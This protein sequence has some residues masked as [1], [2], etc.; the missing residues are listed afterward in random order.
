MLGSNVELSDQI[1][2]A[3]EN[4]GMLS[5]GLNS[6]K[7]TSPHVTYQN[8]SCKILL[9]FFLASVKCLE[10]GTFQ[11]KDIP[12]HLQCLSCLLWNTKFP[13]VPAAALLSLWV[14][15]SCQELNWEAMK[16]SCKC[17]MVQKAW[18]TKENKDRLWCLLS[19]A[20]SFKLAKPGR[21]LP[22]SSCEQL[23]SYFRKIQG[24]QVKSNQRK[25]PFTEALASSM[26]LLS[27]KDIHTNWYDLG[28][29]SVPLMLSLGL[30]AEFYGKSMWQRIC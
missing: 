12:T 15:F 4:A 27:S 13:E 1:R 5:A 11:R 21:S 2:E 22:G 26:D 14:F 8:I 24:K 29:D 19:S 18:R 6:S 17:E 9:G 10:L 3:C 7:L 20:Q 23:H 16:H 25:I 28:R 30:T